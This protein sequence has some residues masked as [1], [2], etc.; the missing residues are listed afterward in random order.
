MLKPLAGLGL[1]QL[2]TGDFEAIIKVTELKAEL[3]LVT[4]RS[5]SEKLAELRDPGGETVGG[6]V[7]P[8]TNIVGVRCGAVATGPATW[9]YTE[10]I[11]W[12]RGFDLLQ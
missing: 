10:R 5:R 11:D 7:L 2:P 9:L 8:S 6:P 4:S 1:S 3:Y 12:S